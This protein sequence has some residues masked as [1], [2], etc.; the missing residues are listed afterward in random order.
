M[1]RLIVKLPAGCTELPARAYLIRHYGISNSQWKRLKHTG[2]FRKNGLSANATHT[3][4]QNGDILTFESE[5]PRNPDA[6]PIEPQDLPLDIRY[7]DNFLIAVNKP[8]GQLVHPLTAEPKGTLANAILGYYQRR[9]ETHHFHP[10]HRLD[11]QTTGLKIGR[12]H[13]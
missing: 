5:K 4:V 9:G 3:M 10:L 6:Y 8:A 12:A 13:V 11:R 2:D 7:E 1:T